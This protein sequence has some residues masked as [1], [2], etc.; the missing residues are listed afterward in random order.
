MLT[1][2]WPSSHLTKAFTG[3]VPFNHQSS[4]AAISNIMKGK[5]P[6][7]PVHLDLT[8][9]LWELMQRCWDQEPRSRPEM[10]EVL[11]VLLNSSVFPSSLRSAI[12]FPD[13]SILYRGS[14]AD[15]H[16]QSPQSSVSA[17]SPDPLRQ[18][19][20]LEKSSHFPELLAN[21]LDGEE[22]RDSTQSLREERLMMLVDDLDRVCSHNSPSLPSAYS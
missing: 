1:S 9:E 7:R 3:A 16:P 18:I 14:S 2:D 8:T 17:P 20:H 5:R 19:H 12:H 4:I 10:S 21:L 22:F 11:R 13:H 15:R 6:P